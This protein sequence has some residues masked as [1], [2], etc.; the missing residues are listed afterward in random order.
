[1]SKQRT[2][3]H[4][5]K[6]GNA[7]HNE[8]GFKK[9]KNV[10]VLVSLD[11]EY[12]TLK[13]FE[14][15][16]YKDRYSDMLTKQNE[17]HIKNRQY[18]RCKKMEEV[19]ES[20][21]Y[22]PTE[23]ILQYGCVETINKPTEE[24]FE[25]MC[26]EYAE[27]LQEWSKEHGGHLQVL[28]LACHFDESTP[29]CHLR[30]IWDYEDEDGIIKIGQEKGMEQ[31]GLSLPDPSKKAGR[32]N[33]RSMTFTALC[34]EKWQDICEEHGY[35]VERVPLP[36][37][38]NESVEEYQAERDREAIK[39][40]E[41]KAEKV[42]KEREKEISRKEIDLEYRE[43]AIEQK[44]KALKEKESNL[45]L[46]EKDLTIQ[47]DNLDV[48]ISA[49][50][51]KGVKERQEQIINEVTEKITK[52]I[53][54]SKAGNVVMHFAQYLDKHFKSEDSKYV[55][56]AT[57]WFKAIAKSKA[58]K[59]VPDRVAEAEELTKNIEQHDDDYGYV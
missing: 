38:G 47:K 34:R 1:M 32:D 3:L 11:V 44:E 31:A 26:V 48:E 27:W 9:D 55:N 6:C 56:L 30:T 46:H 50:V 4:R 36:R 53:T 21:R 16:F 51:S 22:K 59:D 2:S 17:K 18:N 29:H 28:D 39:K 12:D 24:D 41:K 10:N 20:N 45:N 54:N 52:E 8:H 7:N 43:K 37:R 42:F 33:N 15:D 58:K 5:G 23:E 40:A 25:D 49:G 13:D 35:E 14:I 57:S 19:Y